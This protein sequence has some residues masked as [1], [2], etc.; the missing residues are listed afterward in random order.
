[1][2]TSIRILIAALLATIAAGCEKPV[3]YKK[4]IRPI[5]QANCLRCHDGK[6]EGSTAS[7]LNLQTYDSLMKGTKF[8]PVVVPGSAVSSTFYRVV[9]D[10]VDPKIRMPPHNEESL[11]RGRGEP[12]TEGQIKDIELWIDQGAK[13]N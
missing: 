6:G 12:L 3:S 11:A 13:N 2:Q 7:G 8:G 9:T 10:S 4:D 5:L 1:M